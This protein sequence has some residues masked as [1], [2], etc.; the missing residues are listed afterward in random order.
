MIPHVIVTGKETLT[1]SCENLFVGRGLRP[2]V[3]LF[4][5]VL[6]E[7]LSSEFGRLFAAMAIEDTEVGK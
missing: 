6:T 4:E 7:I 1:N 2:K 3:I 5:N